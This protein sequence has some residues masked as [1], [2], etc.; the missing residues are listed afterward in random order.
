MVYLQIV[1]MLLIFSIIVVYPVMLYPAFMIFD[2]HFFKGNY[3]TLKQNM[4]RTFVVLCTI[5]I[6]IASIG[7]FDSLLALVGSVLCT[8][9][10]VIFPSIFHFIIFKD[11]QSKLR[12][13][14]DLFF[15]FLGCSISIVVFTLTIV[16]LF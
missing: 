14:I 13:S 6:G 15:F 10:A 2:L 5:V 7:N 11:S 1:M 8:P 4:F 12:S 16:S 3:Q 9:L